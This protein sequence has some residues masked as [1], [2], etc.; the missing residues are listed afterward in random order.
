[1]DKKIF[2]IILIIIF[3]YY[4]LLPKIEKMT[5][6]EYQNRNLEDNVLIIEIKK[7]LDDNNISTA[8][9]T[10]LINFESRDFNE[11][12][13]L[14][15]KELLDNFRVPNN[16]RDKLLSNIN[17]LL[18]STRLYNLTK[19]YNLNFETKVSKIKHL[20]LRN[21]FINKLLCGKPE[22]IP[23]FWG[24]IVDLV[25]IPSGVE[26]KDEDFLKYFHMDIE[27]K[28]PF[29]ENNKEDI[30]QDITQDIDTLEDIIGETK[31]DT[32]IEGF[33]NLM[34][35]T[36]GGVNFDFEDIN[37]ET[38]HKKEIDSVS[39]NF[40]DILNE[41]YMKAKAKMIEKRELIEEDEG[42]YIISFDKNFMNFTPEMFNGKFKNELDKL[43]LKFSRNY[44]RSINIRN[45]DDIKTLISYFKE[46]LKDLI[47]IIK[48]SEKSD[49]LKLRFKNMKELYPHIVNN[50]LLIRLKDKLDKENAPL[51][52]YRCLSK[53]NKNCVEDISKVF[54]NEN[55]GF[56]SVSNCSLDGVNN[57]SDSSFEIVFNRFNFWKNLSL[58]DKKTIYDELE[59]LLSYHNV[60]LPDNYQMIKLKDLRINLSSQRDLWI[61]NNLEQIENEVFN[62]INN[63]ESIIENK[64]RVIKPEDIILDFINRMNFTQK[65][66]WTELLKNKDF[67]LPINM[68]RY[69]MYGVELDNILEIKAVELFMNLGLPIDKSFYE[70]MVEYNIPI[71][72]IHFIYNK[73]GNYIIYL[74]TLN[75]NDNIQK[76]FY[77]E[78]IPEEMYYRSFIASLC[79]NKKS[80]MKSLD[81]DLQDKLNIE[82]YTKIQNFMNSQC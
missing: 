49:Y 26:C 57:F 69:F 80:I 18:N 47:E 23:L 22:D 43:F 14:S 61:D 45:E 65:S 62:K 20:F 68:I 25:T 29:I 8:P 19:D 4:V 13:R 60:V 15:L 53:N 24:T 70:L 10:R 51:R 50:L 5:D 37:L 39:V 41:E 33:F 11:D 52:A 58:E 1:M 7:L 31:E 78:R 35:M 54:G 9:I 59:F 76:T 64:L 42:E 79:Y 17:L 34:T 75:I 82:I 3:V 63:I 30:T 32:N 71:R 28:K 74:R 27:K 46:E 2:I 16:I 48:K 77:N 73:I 81:I 38:T 36:T 12:N 72:Y 21:K 56:M 55:H 6:C 67:S 44:N 40:Y 66:V